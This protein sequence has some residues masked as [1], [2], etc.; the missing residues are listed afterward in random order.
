VRQESQCG[1]CDPGIAESADEGA[2]LRRKW[3]GTL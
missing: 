1:F 3:H 2:S